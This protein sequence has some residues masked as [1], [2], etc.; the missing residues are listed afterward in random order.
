MNDLLE[1]MKDRGWKDHFNASCFM[2]VKTVE[3]G[4]DDEESGSEVSED[5]EEISKSRKRPARKD[6][7]TAMGR[8]AVGRVESENE[9][10][11]MR[12]EKREKRRKTAAGVV[13][14]RGSL[15]GSRC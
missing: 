2:V 5:A 6:A 12:M 10:S 15:G 14:R 1:E 9:R 11:R 8:R 4:D 3:D 7:S 13:Q